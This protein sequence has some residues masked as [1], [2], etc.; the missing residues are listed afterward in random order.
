MSDGKKSAYAYINRYQ[1]EKIRSDYYIEEGW[2][3]GT[4]HGNS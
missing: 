3:K 1:K 2:R 4:S